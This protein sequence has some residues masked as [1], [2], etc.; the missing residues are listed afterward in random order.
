MIASKIGFDA[1]RRVFASA[2]ARKIVAI[3]FDVVAIPA[4]GRQPHGRTF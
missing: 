3:R 4:S 1:R 2:R